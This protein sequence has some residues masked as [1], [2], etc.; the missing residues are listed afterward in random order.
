LVYLLADECNLQDISWIKPGKVAWDWWNDWNISGVDFE[1]GVNNATYKHYIDFASK[2]GIEYV[3]LDE[4]WAVTGKAD[5]M[6][7]VPEIDLNELVRY[8][9]Q[10]N[11][12]IVL[13]AGYAAVNKD[14][15]GVCRHFSEMGITG[16][17][18]DFMDRDDQIMVGFYN[19]LAEVAAKHKLL[20]DFHG[21]YK[22]TGLQRTFPNVLNYEGVAGLE[23]MKWM[24][25]VDQMEY[26]VTIPF[27]R[28]L[29]GPMDYTQGA[30]RNAVKSNYVPVYTEPMSQGTRCHQ[31]ALYTIFESP[32][33]MLSDSPTNYEKESECTGFIAAIPTVWDRTVVLD[34]KVGEFIVVARKKNDTWY[35]GGITDWNARDLTVGLDFLGKGNYSI[36]LFS[37]GV[38]ANKVATDYKKEKLL[39]SSDKKLTIK[40]A[41]GGGFTAKI[42]KQ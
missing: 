41:S 28:M 8:G 19:R 15:E 34:G 7:V 30:M 17:K 33:N 21:A 31:L 16:F 5:M 9:K 20:I 2:Y 39:T 24:K 36:E 4:G 12:G 22:P 18:V 29:A 38:N 35:I 25:V 32:F 14:M 26:D 23:Q 10:K 37:D 42:I 11:V 1:S 6:Q 27:I 13:W 3:I 40:L